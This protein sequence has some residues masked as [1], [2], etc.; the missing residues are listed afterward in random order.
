MYCTYIQYN[1]MKS[2]RGDT[3]DQRSRDTR[4]L[5]TFFPLEYSISL[6]SFMA[7]RI[8][9]PF[10]FFFFFLESQ[11]PR[12]GSP[13]HSLEWTYYCWAVSIPTHHSILALQSDKNMCFVELKTIS[14]GLIFK[15]D[16]AVRN[17]LRTTVI[18]AHEIL[19]PRGWGLR[20]PMQTIQ[21]GW[22][23]V[24]VLNTWVAMQSTQ[25]MSC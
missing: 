20:N 21:K 5:E 16:E 1:A 8:A 25:F 22:R 10:L 4:F 2:W 18:F 6:A 19:A 17:L 11:T 13:I 9:Q 7:S 24:D 14:P 3:E 12:H 23:N 15:I